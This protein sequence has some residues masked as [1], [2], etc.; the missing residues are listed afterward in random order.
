ML[1]NPP[2]TSSRRRALLAL[3]LLAPAPSVG[4]L[5]GLTFDKGLLG[6]ILWAFAKIWLFGLPVLWYLFVD[7]QPLSWSP[8]RCGGFVTAAILG[9]AIGLMIVATYF[10]VADALIDPTVVRSKVQGLGLTRRWTYVGLAAYLICINSLLEE[11]VYR[12]FIFRKWETLV[13]GPLAVVGSALV[14][15]V[16]HLI[17]LTAYFPVSLVVLGSAGVFVGGLVWSW[18]YRK[19]GSVWPPFVSH[20]LVD[21]AVLIVGYFI[22]FGS[23]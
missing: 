15:V 1:G 12:W 21:I 7:K 17:I 22:I 14:F 20:A 2:S 18:L 6:T 3:L 9:V 16:H 11:Y 10:V 13:G 4:V 19:Y 5:V 8:A 23:P